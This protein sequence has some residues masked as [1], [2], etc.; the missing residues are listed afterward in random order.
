MAVFYAAAH[1][2]IELIGLTSVF[3][4]VSLATATRNALRLAEMTG[5]PVPVAEGAA[6]P[7]VQPLQPHPEFVHG[8]GGF[9]DE[10]P[11]A[12]AAASAR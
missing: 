7:L 8:A 11:A 10:P 1:P 5:Q 6:R 3:G 9:G 12:P 4:N 2:G